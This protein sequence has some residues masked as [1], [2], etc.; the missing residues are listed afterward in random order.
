MLELY[1]DAFREDHRWFVR[2]LHLD[3]CDVVEVVPAKT[4]GFLLLVGKRLSSGGVVYLR[5]DV[6]P[7]I[8]AFPEGAVLVALL[9]FAQR[10]QTTT[11]AAE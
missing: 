1:P 6:T 3:E 10:R 9:G 8:A 7:W 5:G 4:N 2:R 11:K